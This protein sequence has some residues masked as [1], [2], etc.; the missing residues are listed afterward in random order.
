MGEHDWVQLVEE[1]K[2][3]RERLVLEGIKQQTTID[4]FIFYFVD[5]KRFLKIYDKRNA[6]NIRVYVLDELE[7]AIFFSCIDINSLQELQE[8][9]S[10]ISETTLAGILNTFEESGIVFK[11]DDHYLSLPLGY[12]LVSSH[13]PKRE[14]QQLLYASGSQRSL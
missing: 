2:K 6:E 10:H 13:L 8:I 3:E 11:E 4:Q 12:N 14:T 7:R 1:W 5:G 9:F